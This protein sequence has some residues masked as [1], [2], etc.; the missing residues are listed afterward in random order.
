MMHEGGEE[1]PS[2]PYGQH[3]GWEGPEVESYMAYAIREYVIPGAVFMGLVYWAIRNLF[4]PIV[5]D[6]VRVTRRPQ[7]DIANMMVPKDDD[8]E[9]EKDDGENSIDGVQK[10]LTSTSAE[11]D[12]EEVTAEAV[13]PTKQ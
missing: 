5:R 6:G 7:D 9:D 1:Y 8:D 10:C 12:K 2:H 4:I 13:P 3:P 11:E